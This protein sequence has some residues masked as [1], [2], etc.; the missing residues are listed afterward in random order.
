MQPGEFLR[1]NDTGRMLIFLVHKGNFLNSND[2]FS[3][4]NPL[5]SSVRTVLQDFEG[6]FL[7]EMPGWL[8][9]LRGI[10]HQINFV[11]GS[12][13]PNKLAY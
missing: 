1:G 13:F 2:D 4:D 5:P 6:I 11:L 9:L 7:E 12:Q 8:P 3:D 10:K